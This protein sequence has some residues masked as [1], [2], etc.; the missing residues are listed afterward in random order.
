MRVRVAGWL[1][2]IAACWLAVAPHGA[3]AQDRPR[4]LVICPGYD[5]SQLWPAFD[6]WA[7]Q[8]EV[9]LTY[10]H[11]YPREWDVYH[12]MD[13]PLKQEWKKEQPALKERADARLRAWLDQDWDLIA[14]TDG[15][16]PLPEWVRTRLVERAQAN[17][18]LIFFGD[19]ATLETKD[20]LTRRIAECQ[21]VTG[22]A[23]FPKDVELRA[24]ASPGRLL[25]FPRATP[26]PES[27][28]PAED[29]VAAMNQF[30]RQ[31]MRPLLGRN[32]RRES[33]DV[34][35]KTSDEPR[36]TSGV[37]IPLTLVA[38]RPG[39]AT[40]ETIPLTVRA[41][42]APKGA[43]LAAVADRTGR[44]LWQQQRAVP[45]GAVDETF[46]YAI[47]DLGVDTYAFYV[48]A[49][50]L[51]ND[52]PVGRATTTLYQYR[53]WDMRRQWQW[54][55][56][57]DVYRWPSFQAAAAMRLF[58][59]AGLNSLGTGYAT[60]RS[61]WWAERYGWRKYAE[62]QGGHKLWNAPVIETDDDD[63]LRRR[64]RQQMAGM[65]K[66]FG[67]A[68]PSAALTLG[69][70]GEEPGFSKGWGTTYYW[71]TDQ[72]PPVVQRVFQQFLRE[73]YATAAEL[74][75]SWQ[76]PL[77]HW[78]DAVLLKKYSVDGPKF[79]PTEI[80]TDAP[81]DARDQARYVDSTDFFT[82][83]FRKVAR[84]ATE[85]V[86]DLNPVLRT[87]YSLHGPWFKG[88]VG[89][90]HMH[91]LHYPKEYQAIEAA[92]ERMH[93]GGEPCFSLIWNHFDETAMV[94]AGLWSQVA[95]QVTHVNFWL[96]FPLMFNTDMTH[97]RASLVLKRF[98]H[99]FQP[100][101]DLLARATIVP[102]GAAML[103]SPSLDRRY[104]L[105]NLQCAYAA[106]AES[107]F[108]PAFVNESQLDR[109]RLV[110]AQ[111]VTQLGAEQV[112]PL[113]KFVE[114]GGVLITTAGFATR[115]GRGRLFAR[116]PGYGLDPWMGFRYGAA[117]ETANP[118][119]GRWK[120]GGAFQFGDIAMTTTPFAVALHDVAA[121]V[122][123]LARLADGTPA[124]LHRKIGR[125][126]LY[127]F[128][129]LHREWGWGMPI[130]PDRE[131]LRRLVDGIARRHELTP[132]YF[133]ENLAA[134]GS[135]L[136][137]WGSQLFLGADGRTRYLVVF[138]DHRAPETTGR[139]H[140]PAT[141]WRVGD[142]LAG[143]GLTWNADGQSLDL[144]LKPG[145][146]R[147]LR[148]TAP[149][150][151]PEALP[152]KPPVPTALTLPH[153]LKPV[154]PHGWPS[155]EWPVPRMKDSEF[156]AA[157]EQLREVYRTGKT[158]LALS[159]YLFDANSENRHALARDLAEQD[160]PS[161][162]PALERA[163]REGATFL[164]TGEDLGLDPLS[165]LTVTTH[166]PRAL[167]AIAE[168]GRRRD[169]RWAAGSED[170]PTLV[171]TLGKGRLVLDRTSVD[172]VGFFDKEYAAWQPGWWAGRQRLL[173][174]AAPAD[175]STQRPSLT[176][177]Q[178]IA[179]L[180]GKTP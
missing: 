51:E 131:P 12:L 68:W 28:V 58:A 49:W 119:G 86:R 98:L 127:H 175:D 4:V 113:Q 156:I 3:V 77:T 37:S 52:R 59:D 10:W 34:P 15:K 61:L 81:E 135:G 80:V 115:T 139:I 143:T 160:W 106:L 133:I 158:R 146:G 5:A 21:P 25:N 176:E 93:N 162:V 134:A 91:H 164:L 46:A 108:P 65:N 173:D 35:Q 56:W 178:L 122:E 18:P 147:V 31:T 120:D 13:S 129:F 109:A 7:R 123:I 137:Y 55:P 63:E 179:W 112:Q 33:E 102:S 14:W 101:S 142:L 22:T 114:E 105:R 1:G 38:S 165:G 26:Y 66:H 94:S 92:Q 47:P 9:R 44:V 169:A 95:N 74:S 118:R 90:A 57:E 150:I 71:K 76:T 151:E 110:Y 23:K 172:D 117:L 53:P 36:S 43:I 96:G 136:P 97:T 40:G 32:P 48:T 70:L 24:A 84:M 155:E 148:L 104:S 45:G 29:E 20:D 85:T 103:A 121:D 116:A 107:G 75:E 87:F 89:V 138:N 161:F 168:L 99:R 145:D 27:G 54:S 72:A 111:A 159:Y 88:S 64:V 144:S 39:G 152:A 16:L 69:S 177:A 41:E 124:V 128:N 171:L 19:P 132:P 6:Y 79:D 140:W 125:G 73:R 157:L 62:M 2:G 170:N 50:L 83:Y 8:L 167:A 153:G 141:G 60:Q 126:H 78:S 180:T 17:R 82:W 154:V 174:S 11:T 67:D 30:W 163:L 130:R 100:V 166:H 149:G 42:S